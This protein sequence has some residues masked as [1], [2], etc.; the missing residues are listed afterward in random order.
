MRSVEGFRLI[1]A[2][3]TLPSHCGN[4]PRT[5]LIL[6]RPSDVHNETDFDVPDPQRCNLINSARELA[7]SGMSVEDIATNEQFLDDNGHP[8]YSTTRI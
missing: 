2:S 4:V 3:M 6:A 8:G 7:R 1:M 5:F